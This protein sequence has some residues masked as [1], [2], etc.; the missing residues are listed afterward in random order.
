VTMIDDTSFFDEG[1]ASFPEGGPADGGQV[2]TEGVGEPSV[3]DPSPYA[4]HRVRV[5]VGGEEQEVPLAEAL[6]GYQRHADYTRKTQELSEMRQQLE[7]AQTLQQALEANP[8]QTIALLQEQY[9]L[10]RQ[11]AQDAYEASMG[12]DSDD[13][14]W[15]ADPVE[16]KLAH[17]EQRF[18]VWE[19]AQAQQQLERTLQQLQGAY[20]EDFNPQE[21]VLEA[22]R[23]G[24]DDLEGV[25][26]R[27]AFDRFW[28]KSQ[29]EREFAAQRAAE[30]A[31]RE[32]A[33]SAASVV[34]TGGSSAGA[35]APATSSTP[36]SIAEAFALAKSQ[37]GINS[38]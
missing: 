33:K 25:Y 5:K 34:H 17:M 7:F 27:I 24:T 1:D 16:Q 37:L 38:L 32:Q 29:A 15:F 2:D 4:D 6:S 28:A 35:T 3:F 19:Q 14:D 31:K 13:E 22:L 26:K 9:G 12:A 18:Q 21:V 8:A 20:G 11:Q 30:D 36:S 10:T 23:L